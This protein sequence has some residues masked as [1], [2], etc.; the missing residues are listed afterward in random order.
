MLPLSVAPPPLRVRQMSVVLADLLRQ[1]DVEGHSCLRGDFNN[2]CGLS[3][4]HPATS[5]QFMYIFSDPDVNLEGHSVQ[6]LIGGACLDDACQ[7]MTPVALH[8]GSCTYTADVDGTT[9]AISSLVSAFST[10]EKV[11]WSTMD[12]ATGDADLSSYGVVHRNDKRVWKAEGYRQVRVHCKGCL[13]TSW[14]SSPFSIHLQLF[15]LSCNGVLTPFY[16]A[17]LGTS[18]RALSNLQRKDGCPVLLSASFSASATADCAQR[19]RPQRLLQ[20]VS[21]ARKRNRSTG[22]GQSLVW[23][24]RRRRGS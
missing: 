9:L 15:L 13:Q 17:V 21:M 22:R 11:T 19:A 5:G 1:T 20:Y 4:S 6:T 2:S 18:L 8:N 23:V 24:Q 16:W 7:T 10:V 14:A 3:P 12:A